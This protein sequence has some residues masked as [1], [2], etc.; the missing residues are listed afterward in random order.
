MVVSTVV[1]YWY[2]MLPLAESVDESGLVSALSANQA[3]LPSAHRYVCAD[4]LFSP[5]WTYTLME[6]TAHYLTLSAVQCDHNTCAQCDVDAQS[7]YRAAVSHTPKH[8]V[9]HHLFYSEPFCIA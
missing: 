7:M 2:L 1:R 5:S 4:L 3:N 9:L 6:N 8:M